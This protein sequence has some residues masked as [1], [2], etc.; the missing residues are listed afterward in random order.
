M[1]VEGRRVCLSG[2][3]DGRFDFCDVVGVGYFG[4]A[5]VMRWGGMMLGKRHMG[6]TWRV[7]VLLEGWKMGGGS[8]VREMC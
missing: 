6:G 3:R 2:G 5:E 8:V 7:E 1:Y 4:G